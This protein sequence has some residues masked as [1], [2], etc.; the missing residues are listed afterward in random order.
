MAGHLREVKN[1]SALPIMTIGMAMV[2]EYRNAASAIVAIR[3]PFADSVAMT[4]LS[5]SM[6]PPTS[7]LAPH[8]GRKIVTKTAGR[9]VNGPAKMMIHEL[10]G[11][12]FPN[13]KSE[14]NP[15]T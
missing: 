8:E 14:R 10:S 1:N 9:V 4:T 13:T 15:I 2:I 7:H 3:S 6:P 12:A 5:E 11:S